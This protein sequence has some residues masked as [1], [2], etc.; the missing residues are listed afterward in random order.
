MNT[1]RPAAI[2]DGSIIG[3]VT[4]I[5]VL[6]GDAPEILEASSRDGSIFSSAREIVIKA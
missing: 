2:I 4:V 6:R 5:T 3:N 1:K